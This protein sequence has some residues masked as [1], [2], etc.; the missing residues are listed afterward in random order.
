[1]PTL[2]DSMRIVPTSFPILLLGTMD[3]L[4]AKSTAPADVRIDEAPF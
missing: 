4:A 2:L 3:T 1:M